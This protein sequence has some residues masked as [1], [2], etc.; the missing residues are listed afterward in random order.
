MK[1]VFVILFVIILG[2]VLNSCEKQRLPKGEYETVFTVQCGDLTLTPCY[3][4]F[5][6]TETTGDYLIITGHNDT[7][8]RD[9]NTVTGILHLQGA[10]HCTG[11]N[12][13]FDIYS[14]TGTISKEK[15]VFYIRGGLTT[16]YIEPNPATQ[17]MDTS[18][19]FGTFEIKSIF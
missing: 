15:G 2:I 19:A 8:Y 14:I 3:G 11:N 7:L 13:F 16:K 10:N 1:N 5:E 12:C 17:T 9:G 18:D 6:I 4:P